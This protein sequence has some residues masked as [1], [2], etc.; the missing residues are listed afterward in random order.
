MNRQLFTEW[1]PQIMYNHHQSGPAGE[2]IFIP[3]FRDPV[4]H[5]VDPLVTLG[6]QARW[7][8]R[9][10]PGWLAQGRGRQR[11]AHAGTLRWL[12]ER[13]HAQHRH[14]S[15]YDRDSDGNHRQPIADGD[16]ADPGEAVVT[17]ATCRC[18]CAAHV[19][20]PGIDRLL[21]GDE[22]GD[23]GLRGEES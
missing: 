23:S 6:I 19:A 5:N 16:S 18:D 9:C 13:R 7:H 22:S 14:V 15:Q 20:L 8:G 2:V 11:D 12:V 21:D 1:I 10:T 3:P 17:S 4:N